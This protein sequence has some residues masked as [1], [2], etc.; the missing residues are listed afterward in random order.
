MAYAK[1]T[2]AFI[3]VAVCILAAVNCA[4]STVNEGFLIAGYTNLG[5]EDTD[6]P[7]CVLGSCCK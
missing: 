1:L 7:S 2:I 4:G 3:I 6:G 5:P